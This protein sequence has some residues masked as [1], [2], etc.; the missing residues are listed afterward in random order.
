MLIFYFAHFLVVA[1][2]Q[3]FPHR[4]FSWDFLLGAFN[5]VGIMIASIVY[6]IVRWSYSYRSM[7]GLIV[8]P[9]K[10][11]DVI[12]ISARVLAILIPFAHS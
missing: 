8:F 12:D 11:K 5:L 3:Y 7:N 4:S 6:T 9:N 10:T 1:T 2:V